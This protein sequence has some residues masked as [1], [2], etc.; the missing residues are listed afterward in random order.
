[1]APKMI[2]AS[3][4]TIREILASHF[5]DE[6]PNLIE[7]LAAYVISVCFYINSQQLGQDRHDKVLRNIAA[8]AR[9]ESSLDGARHGLVSLEPLGKETLSRSIMGLPELGEHPLG[10][11]HRV[12][13]LVAEIDWAL[14]HIRLT[15]QTLQSAGAWKP[16][17]R[18]RRKKEEA[19]VL[20]LECAAIY[21]EV[22]GNKPTIVT[23]TA[24]H[25]ASGPFLNFV[26]DIFSGLKISGSPEAAA[27][28]AIGERKE[29]NSPSS[30]N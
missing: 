17:A 8:L 26:T 3:E 27:R 30:A 9:I 20:A 28:L 24:T 13:Q 11:E 1:M 5:P 19:R 14:Q 29:K 22:T 23:D 25:E 15:R 10:Y 6:H 7:G 16:R 12:D 21:Q 2:A 4:Q 18:G